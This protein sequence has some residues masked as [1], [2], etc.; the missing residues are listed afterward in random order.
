MGM[1][2]IKA[3]DELA[4]VIPYPLGPPPEAIQK[5]LGFKRIIRMGDN[6]NP[7][8]A[9]PLALEA[10][11]RALENRSFYPDGTYSLLYQALGRYHGLPEGYF[12]AGNGSD[13]V[14]RLLT[15]AFISRENEAV[16]ADCTF[17]RY[18]TNVLIEG[19][20]PVEVPLK[21][22]MH[23]LE[24]MLAKI[25]SKTKMVFVCNPN[26]PTGTIVDKKDLIEFFKKIPENVLIVID[27]AYVEYVTH[28]EMND[29]KVILSQ[30]QNAVI[31]RT[32]SKIHG[33]AGLRVGYGMMDPKIGNELK[34]VRDV[35]NVN[36]IGAAAAAVSVND[37]AFID[38]SVKKNKIE[39]AFVTERLEQMGYTVLPSQANFVFV[40]LKGPAKQAEAALAQKG[41]FV[42]GIVA[43]GYPSA[44]RVAFGTREENE[45][46]LEAI[47]EYSVEGVM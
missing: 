40:L 12:V 5:E 23:D 14:I 46:L 38:L 22:G 13:E 25:T 6:E 31:L 45:L 28:G 29:A 18:K 20:V 16:M 47:R 37:S 34:K 17:P 24:G 43:P 41:I 21:N 26:N 36:R 4:A 7:Y 15:R 8:G 32:F 42:K 33:L 44:M 19:G 27:E 30:Y 3:R 9:S 1:A 35:F 39:R 11:K 2:M 10:A